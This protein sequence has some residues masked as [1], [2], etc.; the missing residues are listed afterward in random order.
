VWIRTLRSGP[1]RGPIFSAFRKAFEQQWLQIPGN[2]SCDRLYARKSGD[3]FRCSI[4]EVHLA[5]AIEQCEALRKTLQRS[6]HQF[7]AINHHAPST[8]L[9]GE[10]SFDIIPNQSTEGRR[11]IRTI[12]DSF[13]G[14]GAN[15]RG[16]FSWL[17]WL[18]A[19]GEVLA[20]MGGCHMN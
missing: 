20:H 17:A 8:P 9:I 3:V 10:K 4:P 6:L 2:R 5:L 13:L 18:V 7:A 12:L 19:V 14:K 1:V 11:A 16:E 15:R